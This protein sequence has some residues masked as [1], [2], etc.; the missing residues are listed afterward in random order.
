MFGGP[1]F[2]AFGGQ[3]SF[4]AHSQSWLNPFNNPNPLPLYTPP[5]PTAQHTPQTPNPHL[6]HFDHSGNK[7]PK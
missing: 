6:A 2:N 5:I 1:P 3:S 4:T 7:S